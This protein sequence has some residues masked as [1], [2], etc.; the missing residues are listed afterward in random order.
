M[1]AEVTRSMRRLDAILLP[2]PA[3]VAPLIAK[4]V[5]TQPSD[6]FTHPFNLTG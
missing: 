5:D 6:R 1:H 3:S 4:E 2:S